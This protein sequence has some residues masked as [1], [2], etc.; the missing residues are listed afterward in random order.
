MVSGQVKFCG[1]GT[2]IVLDAALTFVFCLSLSLYFSHIG[3]KKAGSY[4]K[5]KDD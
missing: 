3:M 5:S 1:A 4:G 2:C